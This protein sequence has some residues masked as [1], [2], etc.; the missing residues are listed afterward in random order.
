MPGV[1][2]PGSAHML[3]EACHPLMKDESSPILDFYPT[4]FSLDPNGHRQPWLWIALL[5]FIDAKRLLE[6]LG[7]VEKDFTLEEKF[8]N[9]EGVEVRACLLS[10]SHTHHATATIGDID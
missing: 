5:P 2:P 7:T 8:R 4:Q 9:T 6:A 10:T 1:Q 3:P